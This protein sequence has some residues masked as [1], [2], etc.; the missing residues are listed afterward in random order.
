MPSS[1]LSSVAVFAS[2]S[3]PCV[4]MK[5]K[6]FFGCST[7]S[8][9]DWLEIVIGPNGDPPVGGSKMPRISK[10]RVSPLGN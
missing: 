4:V 6:R 7:S 5:T 1:A 9:N 2:V 10:V 3:P 8:S